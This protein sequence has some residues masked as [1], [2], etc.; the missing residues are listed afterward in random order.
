MSFIALGLLSVVSVVS[1]IYNYFWT[2]FE[3]SRWIGIRVIAVLY[4]GLF[5]TLLYSRLQALSHTWISLIPFNLITDIRDGIRMAINFIRIKFLLIKSFFSDKV[6]N[7]VSTKVAQVW[8][9]LAKWVKKTVN[10]AAKKITS[11]LKAFV[12]KV[13]NPLYIYCVNKILA[14]KRVIFLLS[15][16]TKSFFMFFI[17]LIR[18]VFE[19]LYGFIVLVLKNMNGL[20]FS[21][22]WHSRNLLMKFGIIGELIFTI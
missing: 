18:K 10:L 6:Y 21:T 11:I 16:A 2:L 9:F 5:I 17:N 3:G 4:M 13:A 22:L 12:D 19:S 15:R 1:L 14:F 8:N 7:P 20:Y